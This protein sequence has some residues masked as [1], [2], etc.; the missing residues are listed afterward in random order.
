MS[1]V[2][3]EVCSRQTGGFCGFKKTK[4]KLT[5]KRTCDKFLYEAEKEKEKHYIEVTRRPEWYWEKDK[6][7]K[8]MRKEIKRMQK[9]AVEQKLEEEK[10]KKKVVTDG[11]IQMIKPRDKKHPLTG[12][13]SRFK[14]T[15]S[16]DKE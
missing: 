6:A 16:D 12:D 7:R 1:K 4:I 14:T 13:L 8:A 3:C 5:K 9:E 10:I 2:K 11:D 15:A